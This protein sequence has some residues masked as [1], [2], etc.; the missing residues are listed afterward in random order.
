MLKR[1]QICAAVRRSQPEPADGERR[2]NVAAAFV[3]STT[4]SGCPSSESDRWALRPLGWCQ[5]GGER[6]PEHSD[7]LCLSNLSCLHS[8]ILT[9]RSFTFLS[10]LQKFS[11]VVR[12]LWKNPLFLCFPSCCVFF[13][14]KRSVGA[15]RRDG[16][17]ASA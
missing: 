12:R 7:K 8:D 5:R 4:P 9:Q 15:E 1:G 11:D 2:G 14:G 16:R 13:P 10:F 6:S 17:S 3:P